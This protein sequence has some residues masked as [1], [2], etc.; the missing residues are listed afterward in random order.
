LQ[1]EYYNGNK[2]ALGKMFLIMNRIAPKLI[3]IEMHKRKLV[4]TQEHIDEL[5][6]DST[7]LVIEQIKNNELVINTSYLAYLRLQVLKVMFDETKAQR[8][9]KWCLVN[10]ID[11]MHTEHMTAEGFK[12]IFQKEQDKKEQEKLEQYAM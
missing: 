6:L 3:N 8:F 4:F 1:Y 7:M 10:H 9:E 5:A 11:I 2:E 12:R